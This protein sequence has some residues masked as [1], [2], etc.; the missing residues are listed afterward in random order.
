MVRLSSLQEHSVWH[1]VSHGATGHHFPEHD[2]L[3]ET[4]M[5]G[6]RQRLAGTTKQVIPIDP[7]FENLLFADDY[8]W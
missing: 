2:F 8:K 5:Q 3:R 6:L 7:F 1:Q 4:T